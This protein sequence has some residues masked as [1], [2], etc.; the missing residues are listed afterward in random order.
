MHYQELCYSSSPKKERALILQSIFV[1]LSLLTI[2]NNFLEVKI[3]KNTLTI[4]AALILLICALLPSSVMAQSWL[5]CKDGGALLSLETFFPDFKGDGVNF[6]SPTLFLTG[7]IPIAKNYY[8]IGE[9]PFTHASFDNDGEYY[10]GTGSSEDIVGN[11]Y[12]GFRYGSSLSPFSAEIGIRLPV[13][14]EEH[15][16]ARIIGQY[17][18]I[19]RLGT[20]DADFLVLSANAAYCFT[21]NSGF[22]AKI[23]GGPIFVIGTEKYAYD[24]LYVQYGFQGGFALNNYSLVAGF[25]GLMLAT[26]DDLDF[27]QRT[28]HQFSLSL[29]GRFG[30]FQPSL[31]LRLPLDDNLSELYSQIIGVG[32]NY[33]IPGI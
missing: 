15:V 4:G 3:M 25:E 1:H 2:N 6:F 13:T 14:T 12:L 10:Y 31:H 20:Y 29:S 22:M 32:L 33:Y 24:D 16:D 17:T 27:G 19:Q 8:F 9:I 28:L 23:I 18:D 26:E 5:N 11:P 30:S 21:E 7:Q